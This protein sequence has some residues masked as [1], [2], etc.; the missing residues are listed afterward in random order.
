LF[1]A[2]L[3]RPYGRGRRYLQRSAG[4]AR[5]RG[6]PCLGSSARSPGRSTQDSASKEE[7]AARPSRRA[8]FAVPLLGFGSRCRP[9]QV[10]AR[11]CSLPRE[12]VPACLLCENE[13]RP[14]R[15]FTSRFTN[16]RPRRPPR[17]GHRGFRSGPPASSSSS[18]SVAAGAVNQAAATSCRPGSAQGARLHAIALVRF[19]DCGYRWRVRVYAH[20]A[21]REARG[22]AAG[23][24]SRHR[25][26]GRATPSQ[27]RESDTLGDCA[28]GRSCSV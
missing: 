25:R 1:V 4:A 5:C 27:P 14:A 18:P 13:R 3:H 17:R 21:P 20:H 10:G 24:P 22:G 28:P 2:E 8:A 7:Q 15:K 19:G 23:R 26:G 6:R 11:G 9:Y 12:V 16:Q